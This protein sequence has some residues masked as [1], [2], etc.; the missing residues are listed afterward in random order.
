MISAAFNSRIPQANLH[1]VAGKTGLTTVLKL[2]KSTFKQT[3]IC[4]RIEDGSPP[5]P[6][7]II[8]LTYSLSTTQFEW[9]TSS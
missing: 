9:L 4:Q 5:P 6:P 7:P 2:E 8:R 1:A 3:L